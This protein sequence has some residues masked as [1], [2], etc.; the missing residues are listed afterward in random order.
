MQF[1]NGTTYVLSVPSNPGIVLPG[2]YWLFALNA[3]GVPSVAA[4]VLVSAPVTQSFS[5]SAS[6][7][8]L[9]AIQ[10]NSATVSITEVPQNGFSGQVTLSAMGLPSGVTAS[11]GTNPTSSSSLLTL[12]VGVSVAPGSYNITVKGVSS[13]LTAS[14]TITFVIAA[15]TCTPS[16]ITPYIQV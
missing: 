3:Q 9:F 5:I 6:Q 16:T 4:N 7:S 13:S 14:T 11:F 15:R 10:G 2:N 8:S 12:T 1:A